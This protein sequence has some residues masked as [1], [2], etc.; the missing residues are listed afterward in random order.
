MKKKD[1]SK[2]DSEYYNAK[3]DVDL[4][5]LGTY[6]YLKLPCRGKVLSEEF[7]DSTN[8]LF[9]FIKVLQNILKK[10]KSI[11]FATPKLELIKWDTEVENCFEYVDEDKEKQYY[12][13]MMV[14]IYDFITEDHIEEAKE[15]SLKK[16]QIKLVEN[17]EIE[18]Y[19][20]GDSIQILHKGDFG[21]ENS[22][23][24]KIKKYME[25][26]SLEENGFYHELN[27]SYPRKVIPQNMKR[28]I[29]VPYKKKYDQV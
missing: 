29:R 28:I 9:F 24:Q 20:I 7:N 25:E 26:N 17:I 18:D 16:K 21:T 23:L 4:A 10:Q 13:I 27:L 8:T 12:W 2:K 5:K 19:T 1:L 15:Y 11:N 14:R 22:S 3:N 6:S